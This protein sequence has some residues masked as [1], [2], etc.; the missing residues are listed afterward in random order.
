MTP[1]AATA[2]VDPKQSYAKMLELE[3]L[4]NALAGAVVGDDAW[5]PQS[6]SRTP[7]PTL[8]IG[9]MEDDQRPAPLTSTAG[10]GTVQLLPNDLRMVTG[11]NLSPGADTSDEASELAPD[12]A[13]EA[14]QR[15]AERVR[16]LARRFVH[17]RASPELDARLEILTEQVRRLM[18]RVTD[19]AVAGLQAMA[20]DMLRRTQENDELA[21]SLGLTG[22]R[23]A[24][25]R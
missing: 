23:R 19:D 21:R 7:F 17:G 24:L 12:P 14:S 4:I 13:A 3:P 16:M 6:A 8:V 5:R 22:K 2:L 10:A 1:L 20:D 11:G 18:P 9:T 15:N 25:A